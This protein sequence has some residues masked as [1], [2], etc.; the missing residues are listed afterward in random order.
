VIKK[1]KV[2][3]AGGAFDFGC[4]NSSFLISTSKDNIL[5]D[6]GYNVFEKLKKD[7]DSLKDINCI[8]VSHDDDDHMGSVKSL[9]FYKYFILNQ[10]NTKV[11]APAEMRPFFEKM[12]FEYN[13]YQLVPAE[14]VEFYN[15]EDI[16]KYFDEIFISIE[17]MHHTKSYGILI[18]DGTSSI[19]ISGDTK[20]N[21][22]F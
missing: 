13:N 6:C 15:I 3:G 8:I 12:N 2:I 9:L 20:A 18:N 4:T 5:F 7:E 10:K 14:I 22:K 16:N 21:A 19:L 17:G 1:V 11:F